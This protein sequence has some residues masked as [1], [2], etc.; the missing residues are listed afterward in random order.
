MSLCIVAAG[1]TTM[2]AATA[3]T[4]MW[5]HS[6]ERVAW[7]EDWRLTGEGLEIVE[8]RIKGSGAG[9][10]PPEGSVFA[11]GWWRYKPKVPPLPE[12]RLATSGATAPWQLCT[13][14]TCLTIPPKSDPPG[15][16]LARCA[17]P[18]GGPA[19]LASPR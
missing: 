3:F 10:D 5:T 4:L 11:G 9:M 12:V 8:A 13:A 16:I 2:L 7:Q 15:V 18:A 14:E 17:N 6:V 19:D 1:K